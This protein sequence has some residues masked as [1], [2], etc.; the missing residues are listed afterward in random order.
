MNT[1]LKVALRYG[2]LITVVL[3]AYFLVLKLFGLHENPWLRL[4]NGLVMASGLFYS[5]K[6]YKL[7]SGDTFSYIDGIKTG[8]ITGFIST[9]AFT[10]FMAV[11][12]FH[13][14]VAFTQTLLGDWFSDY[15]VGAN[16]LLFIIF[17]EGLA[18][19][20][21]LSLAFMQLFKKSR[22]IPQNT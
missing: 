17:I 15:E 2:L 12:M 10:I 9:V 14:D 5:I 19:T 20:V 4:M 21:V 7:I 8:L 22:N 16:I 11:Y 1:S 13:L 3:I 6:Y 18:S